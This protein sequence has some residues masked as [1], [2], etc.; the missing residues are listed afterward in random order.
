ALHLV[1]KSPLHDLPA[2]SVISEAWQARAEATNRYTAC[3]TPDTTHLRPISVLPSLLHLHHVRVHGI[4]AEA[5]ALTHRLAHSIALS[6][7]A[8]DAA[9][10]EE[11]DS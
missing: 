9:G 6:W 1:E 4:D 11:A 8:R 3:L 5:E 10:R 7:N 2:G